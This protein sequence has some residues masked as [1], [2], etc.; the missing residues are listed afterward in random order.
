MDDKNPSAHQNGFLSASN[1]VLI[2][3]LWVTSVA[4][5]GLVLILQS[6]GSDWSSWRWHW[7][8][9]FASVEWGFTLDRLLRYALAVWF[10][11]HL[12][13][14]YVLNEMLKD[15]RTRSLRY[16]I[17]QSI[18]G[19]CVFGSLG[20][21]TQKFDPVAISPHYAFSSAFLAIA[22]IGG[23]AW[24]HNRGDTA[25]TW[26]QRARAAAFIAALI[27][28]ALTFVLGPKSFEPVSRWW[29]VV[30]G[31]VLCWAALIWYWKVRKVTAA[32]SGVSDAT[33]KSLTLTEVQALIDAAKAEFKKDFIRKD[34]L[35]ERVTKLLDE[36][37]A[38]W[39][40]EVLAKI[41][42]AAASGSDL[43][44]A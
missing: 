35:Q 25:Q 21:V 9:Q 8:W 2:A 39:T 17:V 20:F 5:T 12:T 1:K 22:L 43:T 34:E 44:K 42:K 11:A 28:S 23:L 36:K 32:T 18:L 6:L 16:D 30:V 14:A 38:A 31:V 13:I 3:Q 27:S 10:A 24:M 19:F 41:P 7:P 4:G 33:M 40:Q 15:G 26:P 29:I 37:K